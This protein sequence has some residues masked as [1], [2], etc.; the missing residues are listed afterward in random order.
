VQQSLQSAGFD[1]ARAQLE[2]QISALKGNPAAASEVA[3]LQQRIN[4]LKISGAGTT[5]ELQI[6]E[7]ATPPGSAASPRPGLNAIIA[8]FASLLIGVLVVLG[9]DQLR[10]RLGT[11]RELGNMLDLPVL[12]S[13]PFRTRMA[14]AR[15]RQALAALEHETYDALQASVRLLGS[16]RPAPHVL[17][18][19]SALHGEG[20]TTVTANLGRS[21]AR[22]GE[23]TLLISGDLRFPAL[24]EHFRLPLSPGLSDLLG[25]VQRRSAPPTEQLQQ[26]IRPVPTDSGLAV[27]PAGPTPSDP[28]SLLS[29]SALEFLFEWLRGSGYSYIL[30]DSPPILGLGDTPFLAQQAREVLLVERLGRV[31]PEQI[32][33]VRELIERLRLHPFGLVVVGGKPEIS[34]YYYSMRTPTPAS[35]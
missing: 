2:A 3:A 6:S 29:G 7:S 32:E 10:P 5:S 24:H 28:S 23:K 26:M 33:D 15:R 17:L 27:L 31:S 13:I 4:A 16:G 18:I 35:S 8:L 25:A 30:V 11:A 21:L 20:K 22:A 19:T 14:S 34:P 1:I 9:R 12:V